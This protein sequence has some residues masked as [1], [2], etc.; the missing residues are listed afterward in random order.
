MFQIRNE[1]DTSNSREAFYQ[2]GV[3]FIAAQETKEGITTYEMNSDLLLISLKKISLG[4][5]ELIE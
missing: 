1:T 2:Q 3:L 5:N 4:N